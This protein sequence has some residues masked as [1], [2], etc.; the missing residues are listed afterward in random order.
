[1]GADEDGVPDG[2]DAVFVMANHEVTFARVDA[3]PSA[4]TVDVYGALRLPEAQDQRGAAR[5]WTRR[6]L[7]RGGG[8]LEVLGPHTILL[9]GG[10]GS[11]VGV[12]RGGE[13]T[14]K[15]SVAVPQGAVSAV[16]RE[17][18][19]ALVL[20]DKGRRWTPGALVGKVLKV[21][22]GRG[23][24]WS[25][26]VVANT[27]D[28]VTLL[29]GSLGSP[30]GPQSFVAAPGDDPRALVVE[31]ALLDMSARPYKDG[32]LRGMW[33]RRGDGEGLRYITGV[34]EGEGEAPDQV[35][36]W[37]PVEGGEA[38]RWTTSYGIEAGD[39]YTIYDPVQI[40][41]PE[42][43]RLPARPADP[44]GILLYLS[45][46]TRSEVAHVSLSYGFVQIERLDLT[47]PESALSMSFVEVA[48]ADAG[49]SFLARDVRGLSLRQLHLRD[50]HPD[51]D[52]VAYGGRWRADQQRGH[53]LCVYGREV[54]VRDNLVTN[55]NDDML[56]F[57]QVGEAV[58]EGNVAINGGD[59]SWE[60]V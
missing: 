13:L 39:A 55:M 30:P 41:I 20:E 29:P 4:A 18:A 7:V 53:G 5:L 38:A 58:I 59:F 1:M 54:E 36:V 34:L 6:V 9:E 57:S 26:A 32:L 10:E 45:E 8:R 50:V 52:T 2:D 23:R 33:L 12:Q 56:Y 44:W 25:F 15:G 37:P 19:A 47:Q 27:E 60:L 3:A 43:R 40:T 21:L 46:R 35:L 28:T 31:G 17:G 16:L 11:Q 24:L 51:S 14:L 48:H 22:S 42:G 49:C